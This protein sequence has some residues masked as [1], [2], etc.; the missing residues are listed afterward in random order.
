MTEQLEIKDRDIVVPGE[1]IAKG[2]GYI[3]GNG[4]YRDGDTVVAGQMGMARVNGKVIK[5]ISLS[6]RYMPRIRDRVIGKV[7]DVLMSGWMMD[8]NCPYTAVLPIKDASNEFIP[9]GSDLTQY[10][11][12]G[13]YVFT[14]IVNVTSQNLTDVSMK[15]PGLRKLIGGRVIEV[16]APK[17][18]RI[19]GKEGSMIKNETG[20]QIYVG[21]NG[22]IWLTGEPKKENLAV[23][24]IRYIEANSHREGV[25]DKV[26][27]LLTEAKQ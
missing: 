13:E 19:I 2:L 26:K 24:A 27:A 22:R 17:V 4:T 3:P 9:R 10:F 21:Q 16:Q 25:T 18:P 5:I 7:T 11:S 15:V 1:I 20:C 6:G 23:K 12:P 14:E 8:I